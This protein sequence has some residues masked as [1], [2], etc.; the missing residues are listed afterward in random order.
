MCDGFCAVLLPPSPKSQFH[1][2]GSPV[3]VSV[4]FTT[5]GA[6]PSTG[7]AVKLACNGGGGA[8]TVIVARLLLLPPGPVTV[9]V[10][11]KVP[12]LLKVCDGFCA[13]LCGVPSPKFQS[14][15]VMLPVDW[16]V[17]CTVNGTWPEVGFAVK[18]AVGG[19]GGG[20]VTVMVALLLS[21]PPGPVTVSVAV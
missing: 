11:V 4:K 5:S 9:S 3:D 12:A 10:T 19:G 21:L 20:A 17:N 6:M 16:S 18:F 15:V 14:H 7:L 13:E 8:V 2:T 1:E